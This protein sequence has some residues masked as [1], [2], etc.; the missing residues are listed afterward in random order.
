M[1]LTF[2]KFMKLNNLDKVFFIE[3]DENGNS[4]S[5]AIEAEIADEDIL[6]CIVDDYHIST[7]NDIFAGA[8][9]DSIVV[10]L[11]RPEPKQARKGKD[12]RAGMMLLYNF[13]DFEPK[14]K[15]DESK[16]DPTCPFAKGGCGWKNIRSVLDDYNLNQPI[17]IKKVRK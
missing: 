11:S 10:E 3:K 9:Q 1:A 7:Q 16:C 2:K 4:S 6:N 15:L 14:C 12:N 5:I 8:Q 13:F 17:D